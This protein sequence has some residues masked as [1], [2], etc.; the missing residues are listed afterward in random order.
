MQIK[1]PPRLTASHFAQTIALAKQISDSTESRITLDASGLLFI[2]PFTISLFAS[3]GEKFSQNGG[4]LEVVNLP[5]K[6]SSYLTRMDFLS[7]PW[8]VNNAAS[9]ANRNN[10]THSLVELKNVSGDVD[11]DRLANE[12]TNAILGQ[13]PNL[14]ENEPRDEMTGSNSWDKSFIP[15]C[16]IFSEILQNS[17]THGRRHGYQDSKVW[18]CAQYYGNSDEIFIGIV[19]NGCGILGSL[20]NH[21]RLDPK[22]DENALLL[23]LEPGISCNRAVGVFSSATNAGA[24]L[25]ITYRL[26]RETEGSML[27]VSGKSAITLLKDGNSSVASTNLPN[28][29][30]TALSI[31]FKRTK[32][33]D[34]NFSALMPIDHVARKA[35]IIRFE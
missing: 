21:E 27:M 22:T 7:L 8:I 18:L 24:G 14:D 25:T 15:I 6:L 26:A 32:L 34:V 31:S 9:N 10:Q 33:L 19:D 2:D 16:H 35:P 28:W 20:N 11:T 5:A 3:A 29:Q 30:G 23:A 13:I 4:S 12:L 17:V 1:I